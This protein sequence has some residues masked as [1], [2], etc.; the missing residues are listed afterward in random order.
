M[1]RAAALCLSIAAAALSAPALAE[2]GPTALP[3]AAQGADIDERLGQ[4]VRTDIE[5]TDMDGKRVRL[6]DYM[7]DGKPIVMVLAYYRCPMLC[8]L[9]LRGLITSM[10]EIPMRPGEDYHALA[11]SFDPRDR[12][13]AAAAK[14]KNVLAEL[15]Q[16]RGE[17]LPEG[18]FPFFTGEEADVRALAEDLGFQYA[19]DEA[20]DQYAHPAT[21]FVLTPEGRISRYLYGV[22]YPPLQMRL[23]LVEASEGRVGGIVDRIIMTCYRYDPASRRYGPYIAGFFRLGGVAILG[24]VSTLLV[25]LWRRDRRLRGGSG[26]GGGGRQ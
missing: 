8:D 3:P 17:A 4:R 13:E 16:A 6:G 12:P 11:V 15:S 24:S 26:A 22:N 2:G 25:A 20:T 23:A 5:L 7:G 10:A 9:V 19:Y 18:A 21:I 14:R 1:I